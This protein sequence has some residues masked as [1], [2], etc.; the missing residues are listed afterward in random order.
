MNHFWTCHWQNR[1][2]TEEFNPE[3]ENIAL[4]G[5]NQFRRR[6]VTKGDVVYVVSIRDGKLLLGGRMTVSR[7]VSREEAA[8]FAGR[9]DLYEATEWVLDDSRSGTP[10]HLH[11]QLDGA[12]TRKLRFHLSTARNSPK[13]LAFLEGTNDLDPQ[14]T[15]G[16]R[17]LTEWSAALLDDI[18]AITDA[19][20][21]SKRMLTVK[22]AQI[23]R[24]AALRPPAR[25]S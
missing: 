8:V 10:L 13:E 9:T 23:P 1:F 6:N 18:L 24:L 21:R 22:E 2:W 7:I 3:F 19:F 25:S 5:S 14:A 20:P 11:R 16:I 15:R 12:V 4:S 17:E